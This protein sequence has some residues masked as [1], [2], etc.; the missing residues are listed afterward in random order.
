MLGLKNRFKLARL[1]QREGLPP[2]H[3]LTEWIT[4]MGWVGAAEEDGVRRHRS[5]V[6][7][8]PRERGRVVDARIP[9]RVKALE[10]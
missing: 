3:R 9:E 8:G 10:A 2:L 5:G 7:N 6:G 1:L 4:V